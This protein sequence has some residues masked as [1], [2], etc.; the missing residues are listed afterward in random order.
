MS[1]ER[2]HCEAVARGWLLPR[3][4]GGAFGVASL[5][6]L[7]MAERAGLLARAEAAEADLVAATTLGGTLTEHE[8][9]QPRT[10]VMTGST[11]TKGPPLVGSMAYPHYM[12]GWAEALEAVAALKVK[13]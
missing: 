8:P 10:A 5:A 11:T 9:V 6:D 13:P 4:A 12:R 1:D 7:I 2:Q 3:S